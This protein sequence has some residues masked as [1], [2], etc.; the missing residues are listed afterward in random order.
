MFPMF[1]WNKTFDRLVA[2][3]LSLVVETR[4]EAL[5]LIR[6][7]GAGPDRVVGAIHRDMRIDKQVVVQTVVQFGCVGGGIDAAADQLIVGPVG[8]AASTIAQL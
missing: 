1:W 7:R 8:G 4:P 5:G 3:C 2:A 6:C